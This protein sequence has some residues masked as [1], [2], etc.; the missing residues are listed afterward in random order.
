MNSLMKILCM[1]FQG[2]DINGFPIDISL[3]SP[4]KTDELISKNEIKDVSS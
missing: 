1:F 2:N 3:Y 4:S